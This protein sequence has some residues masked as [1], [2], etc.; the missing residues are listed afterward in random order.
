MRWENVLKKIEKELMKREKKLVTSKENP[1]DGDK[2]TL[3]HEMRGMR[4][5]IEALL[6][7]SKSRGEHALRKKLD[8][9]CDKLSEKME[10]TADGIMKQWM[11]AIKQ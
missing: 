5:V 9:L 7:K 3:V 10:R 8:A 4:I 6:L 11:E 1:S 2:W